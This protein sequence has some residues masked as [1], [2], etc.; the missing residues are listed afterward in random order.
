MAKFEPNSADLRGDPRAFACPGLYRIVPAK[1]GGICRVRIPLGCL[2]ADQARAIA[3]VATE[4][5]N[6]I[7]ELTNR[8]NIQIRG[9]LG[10]EQELLISEL[11]DSGLGTGE[12]WADD[13]RNV[14]MNPSAGNDPDELIDVRPIAAAILDRFSNDIGFAVLSPKFA[15]QIDGGGA[16]SLADHAHDVWLLAVDT[17]AHGVM[18]K[19]GLGGPIDYGPDCVDARLVRPSECLE[20]V[21]AATLEFIETGVRGSGS[22]HIRQLL[23]TM[24]RDAIWH[25]V[26]HRIGRSLLKI[27]PGQLR[28]RAVLVTRPPVGIIAQRVPHLRSVGAAPVLGRIDARGLGAVADIATRFGGGNLR[29]TPW[30]SF[31]IPD[32]AEDSAED[33]LGALSRAGLVCRDD[34]PLSRLV[35]CAGS[36]GCGSAKTDAK[37]DAQLLAGFLNSS[38]GRDTIHVSGCSKSCAVPGVADVTLVGVSDGLYDLYRRSPISDARFGARMVE[39]VDIGQAAGHILGAKP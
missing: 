29:L 13:T 30:R 12:R 34:N 38:I 21:V 1:D 18:F 4:H 16:M 19:M 2:S 33:A 36:S 3:S 35:A 27:V 6:G 23:E 17:D 22:T 37:K 15:L 11:V 5:G 14:L 20:V 24:T 9:I 25:R 8:G 7:V 26:E 28:S 32:V 10:P 39:R 31:L